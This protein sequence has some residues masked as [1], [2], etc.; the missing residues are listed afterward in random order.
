[1]LK[2]FKN[3]KVLHL[4]KKITII[5]LTVT[6]LLGCEYS[7]IKQSRASEVDSQGANSVALVPGYQEILQKIVGPQCLRC[8]SA[9]GGNRG[10][11][12]LETLSQLKKFAQD[13]RD[14]VDLNQ[15]PPR[16]PLTQEEKEL[17]F[18]WIDAGLPELPINEEND[19]AGSKPT[20]P[21]Q[22]SEPTPTPTPNPTPEPTPTPQ[23]VPEDKITF[24]IIQKQILE[25]ACL[26]CHS[27]EGGNRG[28]VN[29]ETYRNV[30]N[31][32]DDIQDSINT[33]FMPPRRPLSEEQKK[34]L[35]DWIDAGAPEL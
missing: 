3:S 31:L 17:L 13:I 16:A 4:L 6:F 22:T 35:M 34:L 32:I 10:G 15:M 29:L 28:G 18:K 21:P 30:F 8:H 19:S 5:S 7:Q 23:P 9:E 25:P 12:N 33:N 20:A 27:A 24:S 11:V 1:M 14:V 26:R 2:F